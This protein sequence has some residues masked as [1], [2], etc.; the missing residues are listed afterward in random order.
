[1]ELSL[2]L[3]YSDAMV[4]QGEKSSHLGSF[5]K[6]LL[7]LFFSA[8]KAYKGASMLTQLDLAGIY[9]LLREMTGICFWAMLV[10][11]QSFQGKDAFIM[12]VKRR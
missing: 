11:A 5:E 3:I 4:D 6:L 7:D 12:M 1:M 10:G 8:V 9:V 2:N